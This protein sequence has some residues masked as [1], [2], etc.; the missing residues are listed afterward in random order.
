[1]DRIS[2][3]DLDTFLDESLSDESVR[4]KEFLN[5]HCEM[6]LR[7]LAWNYF[8]FDLQVSEFVDQAMTM[9]ELII[10]SDARW[11]FPKQCRPAGERGYAET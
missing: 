3:F 10:F 4:F 2:A 5:R 1:V 7:S 11:T 8:S 6:K 9:E